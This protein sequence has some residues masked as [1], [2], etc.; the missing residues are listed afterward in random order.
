VTARTVQ[1]TNPV[2]FRTSSTIKAI[3]IQDGAG[4][5]SRWYIG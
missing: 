4:N 3:R 5:W 2:V 1:F